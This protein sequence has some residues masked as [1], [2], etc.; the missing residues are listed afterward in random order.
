MRGASKTVERSRICGKRVARRGKLG[1]HEAKIDLW[2]LG[3]Q[4]D[5]GTQ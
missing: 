5:V 3:I 4:K 1:L 2:N